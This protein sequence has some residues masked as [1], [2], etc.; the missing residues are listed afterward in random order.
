[1]LVMLGILLCNAGF[2]VV[3][4]FAGRRFTLKRLWQ[5][6]KRGDILIVPLK[7]IWQKLLDKQAKAAKAPTKDGSK[8]GPN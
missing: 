2:F 3:G 7:D 1:M 4:F 5:A 6:H 8:Y